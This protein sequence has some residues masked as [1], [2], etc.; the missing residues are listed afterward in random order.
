MRPI[1]YIIFDISGWNLLEVKKLEKRW[2][3]KTN[4]DQL[5]INLFTERPDFNAN[6]SDIE[7]LRQQTLDSIRQYSG[8]VAEIRTVELD[9]I[10]ALC[11]IIKIPQP[12]GGYVYIGTY[13][14]AFQQSS[15]VIKVQCAET[16]HIGQ[17]ETFALQ[18]LI[19]SG[20]LE[21]D[22]GSPS[23][24]PDS[25]TP[26]MEALISQTSDSTRFDSQ[27][28]QHPLSRTRLILNHIYKTIQLNVALKKLELFQHE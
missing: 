16:Q 8:E 20:Q 25:I 13:T 2:M 24:S 21:L 14:L 6:L 3:S 23:F 11:L 26:E 17:R 9:D 27:F 18:Q 19:T 22:I 15:Y 1:D 4:N 7:V 5:S 12:Q 10:P 28:P